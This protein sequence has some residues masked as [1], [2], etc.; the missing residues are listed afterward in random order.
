MAPMLDIAKITD[1]LWI[2]TVGL[3]NQIEIK[4][5]IK[6]KAKILGIH[7]F[8]KINPPENTAKIKIILNIIFL[9]LSAFAP[10]MEIIKINKVAQKNCPINFQ[11]LSGGRLTAPNV[12]NERNLKTANIPNPKVKTN[13]MASQKQINFLFKFI[14]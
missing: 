9:I 13:K 5:T 4:I 11:I 3:I 8:N 2:K 14:I 1:K 12:K 7:K 10:N 6:I